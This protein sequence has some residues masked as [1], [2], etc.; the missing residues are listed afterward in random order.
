MLLKE[1]ISKTA[2]GTVI[3]SELPWEYFLT[4][5]LDDGRSLVSAVTCNGT[6]LVPSFFMVHRSTNGDCVYSE[7]RV[8]VMDVSLPPNMTAKAWMEI[9]GAQVSSL[10]VVSTLMPQYPVLFVEISR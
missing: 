1:L 3:I 5:A 10:R 7:G 4:A 9:E 2:V 6:V 8:W